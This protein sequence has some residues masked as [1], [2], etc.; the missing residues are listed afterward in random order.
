MKPRGARIVS[1]N[2]GLT[3]AANL[4]SFQNTFKH[5]FNHRNVFSFLQI[6]HRDLCAG[7]IL[8]GTD[9]TAKIADLGLADGDRHTQQS[10]TISFLRSHY[11]F[12][13]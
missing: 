2:N 11:R 4:N 7:N 3:D 8:L 9:M 10:V 13:F 12:L 6:I 1:K 5:Q